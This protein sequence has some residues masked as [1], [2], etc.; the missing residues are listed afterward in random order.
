MNE[1]AHP[2]KTAFTKTATAYPWSHPQLL[3][4]PLL[5]RF[6]LE[7]QAWDYLLAFD[8]SIV[9]IRMEE[10]HHYPRSLV[11]ICWK[12]TAMPRNPGAS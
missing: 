9:I 6:S 4:T 10:S 3:L 2:H 11:N 12:P 5:E 1:R 7:R 8:I